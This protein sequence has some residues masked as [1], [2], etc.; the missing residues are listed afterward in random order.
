M[1]FLH[2]KCPIVSTVR[3]KSSTN[4]EQRKFCFLGP[5]KIFWLGCSTV[6]LLFNLS[7][8]ELDFHHHHYETT[9]AFESKCD[10]KYSLDISLEKIANTSFC[11]L[12]PEINL[13]TINPPHRSWTSMT[14]PWYLL[15]YIYKSP[16]QYDIIRALL[17]YQLNTK[18]MFE[19]GVRVFFFSLFNKILVFEAWKKKLIYSFSFFKIS[20]PLTFISP[21]FL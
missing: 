15:H 19:I 6:T 21:H 4:V 20:S 11:D 17:K 18:W 10:G 8:E 16:L 3:K 7:A 2:R 12:L 13:E 14:K 1:F 9:T 5:I